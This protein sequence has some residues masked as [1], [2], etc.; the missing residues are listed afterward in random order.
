MTAVLHHLSAPAARQPG[1]GGLFG[2]LARHGR[3]LLGL[4]LISAML[5]LLALT[6][7]LFMMQVYDRVIPGHS[8]PT[9]VGLAAIVAALYAFQA[10]FEIVRSR[11]LSH[12][13]AMLDATLSGRVFGILMSQS[14]SQGEDSKGLQPL[15]D[16]DQVR[17]FLSGPGPS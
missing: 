9:L 10:A 2:L 11:T 5:N 16:L 12:L 15:R 1:T 7:S 3:A 6:G 13:G 4:G 8:V 17:G 14:L